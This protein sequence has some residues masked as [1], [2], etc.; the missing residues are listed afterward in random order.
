MQYRGS[1]DDNQ[2]NQKSSKEVEHEQFMQGDS[3]LLFENWEEIQNQQ[4][5]SLMQFEGSTARHQTFM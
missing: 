4:L 1:T 3:G 5:K 2:G